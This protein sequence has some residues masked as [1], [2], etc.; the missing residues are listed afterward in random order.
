MRIALFITCLAD[1]MFPQVGRAT[2]A[3]LE[4]LGHAVVF[5]AEQTCCG[6][7]HVNT[8]YQKQAL[9][10]VRAVRRGVRRRTTRWSRRRAPASARSG[11]S[12]RWSRGGSARRVWS[13]RSRRG[14][15]DV[16]A[17]RAAGRRAG[18][19]RC[20]GL[21]PAPGDLSPDLSLAADAAGRGQAA[22]AAAGGRRPGAGGA[23]GGR[24]VLR[25]RRHVRDQE[26]RHL[27]GDAGRQDA[28]RAGHRRGDLHGRGQ[29]LPDAHRRRTVPDAR[30]RPDRPSGPDPG[31]DPR[32]PLLLDP[33][34]TTHPEVVL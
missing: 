1:A 21:L 5:P 28:A 6:Q 11:T 20:R 23:A 17:V 29:L 30:R 2:V 18:R 4:R 25:V 33:V 7:M 34:G 10:L 32:E 13:S 24:A 8:G 14:G 15:Q 26:R 3:V 9:P 16:R 31:L 22:P 27:D 12:T 19:D